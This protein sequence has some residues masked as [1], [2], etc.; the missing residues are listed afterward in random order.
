LYSAGI[1]PYLVYTVAFPYFIPLSPR[2]D[3]AQ[4]GAPFYHPPARDAPPG[5]LFPTAFSQTTRGA[6]AVSIG[7]SHALGILACNLTLGLSLAL[8]WAINP[9]S[10]ESTIDKLI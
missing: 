8:L 10:H 3:A 4:S 7:P 2:G 5:T 6:T 9:S 1:S